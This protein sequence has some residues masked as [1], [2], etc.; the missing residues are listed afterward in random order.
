MLD[1]E[2]AQ[3]LITKLDTFAITVKEAKDFVATNY[4]VCLRSRTRDRLVLEISQACRKV[5][6]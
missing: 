1:R 5:A 2:T 6:P 3:T 4:G